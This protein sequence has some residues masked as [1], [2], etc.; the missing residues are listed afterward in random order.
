M[1]AIGLPTTDK[2]QTTNG[3]GTSEFDIAWRNFQNGTMPAPRSSGTGVSLI[4][5]ALDVWN[6]AQARYEDVTRAGRLQGYQNGTINPYASLHSAQLYERD[7]SALYNN[8]YA[9]RPTG[10]QTGVG[11][12]FAY[13]RAAKPLSDALSQLRGMLSGV[14]TSE[15]YNNKVVYP[16]K[17]QGMSSKEDVDAAL[18][19]LSGRADADAIVQ[20]YAGNGKGNS[21]TG[22]AENVSGVMHDLG[23]NALQNSKRYADNE[24]EIAWL[25]EHQYDYWSDADYA[26]AIK[27]LEGQLE[28]AKRHQTS[29]GNWEQTSTGVRRRNNGSGYMYD[30][31]SAADERDEAAQQRVQDLEAQLADLKSR[32][33][34]HLYMT[35]LSK[36]SQDDLELLMSYGEQSANIQ[37][38]TLAASAAQAGSMNPLAG[39]SIVRSTAAVGYGEASKVK[40]RLLDLGYSDAEAEALMDYIVKQYNAQGRQE[41][42]QFFDD[43][44]GKGFLGQAA[45][46]L[47]GVPFRLAGGVTGFTDAGIQYL[48]RGEDPF[49]GRKSTIDWNTA[50]QQ[51]FHAGQDAS[52]AVLNQ[53]KSPGWQ[54]A[55]NLMNSMLDSAAVA[56]IPGGE[57]LLGFS[58][59]MQSAEAAKARGA[60]DGQALLTGFFSGAAETACEH[61]PLENIRNIFKSTESAREGLKGIVYT[62]AKQSLYEGA[63]EAATDI[64]N[65]VTDDMIMGGMSEYNTRVRE[66]MSQGMSREEAE[67]KAAAE[68]VGTIFED[69]AAGFLSG[70]LMAGGAMGIHQTGTNIRNTG[71]GARINANDYG[72]ELREY[73]A[74]MPEGSESQRLLGKLD[75]ASGRRA[76]RLTGALYNAVQTEG[77]R[78]AIQT[79]LQELGATG[80]ASETAEAIRLQAAGAELTQQQRALTR[81]RAAQRVL[82]EFQSA[83]EGY[84]GM[85]NEWAYDAMRGAQE[86]D[87][88][89]LRR[90]S[91]SENVTRSRSY[92]S[93]DEFAESYGK[94]AE[95]VR[96][97]YALTPEADAADFATSFDAAYE[98]GQQGAK[99]EAVKNHNAVRALEPE[100]V[101]IAWQ[102]G[103][104]SAESGETPSV[105]SADS[106]LREGAGNNTNGGHTNGTE[107]HLRRGGERAD[108]ART[109]GEV[110]RMAEASKR[111]QTGK[112]AADRPADSGAL[113]VTV[114]G[115]ISPL[116]LGVENGS[117][118]QTAYTVTGNDT[119]SMKKARALA[120]EHGMEVVFFAG[121]NLGVHT[122]ADKTGYVANARGLVQGNKVFVRVDHPQFTADQIMRHE[123]GHKAIENGEIDLNE[124]RERIRNEFGPEQFDAIVQLYLDAYEGTELTADEIWEEIVCDS[125][126]DMNVFSDTFEGLQR[127]TGKLLR[128]TKKT[129]NELRGEKR[130]QESRAPPEGQKTSLEPGFENAFDEW[131]KNT[132]EEKRL[133]DGGRF[134][135]GV[136]SDKLQ[137]AGVDEYKIYFGKS[138]IAKIM[139]NPEMTAAVIKLVPQV[140][141]DPVIVMDSLTVPGSITMFGF[142]QTE[143]GKPVMVSML[144]HPES[145]TGEVLDYGVITSAYGRKLNNAQS[146]INRS[147]IRYIDP[148]TKRTE[149]WS[150][151]LGLH[152]PSASTINGSNNSISDSAE[153]SKTK[154]S[155][156]LDTRY[157]A[158]VESGDMETAQ[159]LVDEAAEK[160][161]YTVRAYHGTPNGTFNVFREWQY[162][163]ENK[164][165]ADRYQNQGASSNGYKPTATRPRTYDVYL[166]LENTFDTRKPRD[167]KIFNEEFYRQWGNGA[168]LSERGL[169][170]WTDGDD[171]AEF[172]D[173]NGYDY[174]S[175]YLDEGGTGGYGEEVQDRGISIA[176]KDPSQIKSA[177]PVTYDDNGDVVPLSKR[178]NSS[179]PDIRLS[180]DLE[181][182][183][184]LRREN[185]E[186]RERAKKWRRETLRSKGRETVRAEDVKE[187]AKSLIADMKSTIRPS[188]ITGDLT[189]L[190][191]YMMRGEGRNERTPAWTEIKERAGEIAEKL[192]DNAETMREG[193]DPELYNDMKRYVRETKMTIADEDKGDIPNGYDYFRRQNVGILRL[194]KDGLSVD[195]AYEQLQDAYGKGFFPDEFTHPADQLMRIADVIKGL[196]PV[197]ENPHSYNRAE[198]VEWAS[199]AIIDT[200][201][202]EDV[203][204]APPTFADRQA[205]KYDAYVRRSHAAIRRVREQRDRQIAKVKQEHREQKVRARERKTRSEMWRG[206]LALKRDF[207][208]MVDK[209]EKS[210]SRHAP[211]GLAIALRN[212]AD[213]FDREG[214]ASNGKVKLPEFKEAVVR[215]RDEYE[216]MKGESTLGF[217]YDPV[218]MERLAAVNLELRDVTDPEALTTGQ[219]R[220]IYDALRMCKH[221]ITTANK[222]IAMEY[223]KGITEAGRQ[224]S[225]E[226][227]N[228]TPLLKKGLGGQ[229]LNYQ[230]RPDSFFARISGFAKNSVGEQV[231][232]MFVDGT[233]KMLRIQQDFYYSLE[234]YST[235][236]R[237]DALTK[238]GNK[239]LV[240][241]GLKDMDGNTVKLTRDQMLAVYMHLRSED[242]LRAA[243][244]GGIDVPNARAYYTGDVAKSFDEHTRTA[245]IDASVVELVEE[246]RRLQ[247]LA[248]EDEARGENHPEIAARLEE[249]EAELQAREG[250]MI[251]T[252][253]DVR[254][255]I[256][257][258]LTDFEKELVQ[259]ADAWM[260][261]SAD[262]INA[263]T[264][265]MYGIE[266]AN[267]EHYWPIHRNTSFVNTDLRTATDEI[268]LENWGSLKERVRSH[269][270]VKLTGFIFE[271]DNHT[272]KMSQFCGFAAVQRDFNKLYN[273]QHPGMH[274]S[275]EEQVHKK[276]GS[277]EKRLGVSGQE[278]IDNYIKSISGGEHVKPSPIAWFRMNLPRATLSAN[279]RVALSQVASVPTA[280]AEVGW[281]AMAKGFARYSL[282]GLSAK[283]QEKLA[284]I[285]PW[286]WQRSRGEGG[287]REFAE[288]KESSFAF[289]RAYNKVAGTKVGKAI[290][291]WCQRFDMYAT[292]TQWAMAE[293]WVKKNRKDLE[294]GSAAWDEAVSHKYRDIIRKTQPNYTVTERSDLLRD[295]RETMKWATM[296]KTQSSQNLNILYDA[297]ARLRQYTRDF[298]NGKNGVTKA[299]LKDARQQFAR[300]YTGVILGGTVTFVLFRALA[301]ALLHSMNAYRDDDEELTLE[302]FLNGLWQET[303]GSLAGMF[304]L[305][306]ELEEIIMAAL[307]G[308]KYWGLS[309]SAVSALSDVTEDGL[310]LLNKIRSGSATQ[311]DY[312]KFINS[313]MAPLGIP[314]ENVEKIVNGIR[315]HVE[316]IQN[317]EFLSFEAG[318]NRTA[319]QQAHRFA[320]AMEDGDTAKMERIY[321]EMVT[322]STAEDPEGNTQGALRNQIKAAFIGEDGKSALS[323]SEAL[324]LLEQ[325]GGK[326][327]DDAQ[328]LLNK[329]KFEK[330][331]GFKYDDLKEAYL[332]GSISGKEYI[333]ARVEYAGKSEEEAE[334]EEL[335]LRCQKDYGVEYGE[336]SVVEAAVNGEI[337]TQEA[338]EIWT[339]YGGLSEKEAQSR[340][341]HLEFV[342]EHPETAYE[343]VSSAAV[344]GY[345]EYGKGARIPAEDFMEYWTHMDSYHADVDANGNTVN[346]SKKQKVVDYINGLR[347][348]DEQKTALYLA[349]GY[350]AKNIPTWT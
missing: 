160:A 330:E 347:I 343:D 175:I 177:D 332:D 317:G 282:K 70:G 296:Y 315:Y 189:A 184:D 278:Y 270:P 84:T 20:K 82:T 257:K 239:A 164:E 210:N 167:R 350:S 61:L 46:T 185:R 13:G 300:A 293:E 198:A 329:W 213:C 98:A 182:L 58:A 180:Q 147:N 120:A 173:E 64:L 274:T 79:R 134:L 152:L 9:S 233:E 107:V 345:N 326:S 4:D 7:L 321:R 109:L 1:S 30:Q 285:D 54:F 284:R 289:D 81:T 264:M 137:N 87:G 231:Q 230:L 286:F 256:E 290:L 80:N 52:G 181:S 280:A 247:K 166:K 51:L 144:L 135:I 186:L 254:A 291:N 10:T 221:N 110:R 219:L 124:V 26:N 78:Q 295:S 337:T 126:G 191:E 85:T 45:S 163:T 119:K 11:T 47:L 197:Y 324:K 306:S 260:R 212:V 43:L 305:G 333:S 75:N 101:A 117:T 56:P 145:K 309:D 214:R 57:V 150:K 159:R 123:M 258:Q 32:Q 161:G 151:A 136:T 328:E 341:D 22:L 165:Y 67:R 348:S 50:A 25:T 59:A 243:A 253:L 267:V 323:E 156:D 228:A 27:E 106:S 338:Y 240:D 115:K 162:F 226:I 252:L 292:Y 262:Y 195:S 174:D 342:I 310:D 48:M 206:I 31:P 194:G 302:S 255:E 176:V 283:Q 131:I 336:S 349:Y 118:A 172:F 297:T 211:M 331:Y 234:K 21:I 14:N 304:L 311:D 320:Q 207:Q 114:G 103:K 38:N 251:G 277:G 18:A 104:D 238:R 344:D 29:S 171:F 203:R 133:R 222:F 102:M 66:L 138:K 24:S 53:I 96:R 149:A 225:R 248:R 319:K 237:F 140:V 322:S 224:W 34:N 314:G 205:A 42:A 266:K 143:N 269:A 60:S 155:R 216:S 169:P 55:Y 209:P 339:K 268:N 223:A 86:M 36:L 188:E 112:K 5:N 88:R 316:D 201:L 8:L 335:K 200:L 299:D 97:V 17:Y 65:Y 76:N 325:F 125:L 340:V 15:D 261:K 139:Q 301:N 111:D 69:A 227:M 276:F 6:Q 250:K 3:R 204:Q 2:V 183:A 130:E 199:N 220:Q 313:L 16:L 39:G 236:K 44:A 132:T 105:R 62:L 190:A 272:K 263:E 19:A 40:Q 346:G 294:K 244:Y 100:Q 49:T 121:G 128:A 92:D 235:D 178:F 89:A 307:T 308:G 116:R 246:Q 122:R 129:A 33:E 12:K 298:K 72:A 312:R 196:K 334:K 279:F 23:K 37:N 95:A 232:Q 288:M 154:T 168:P 242:N 141:E 127:K 245:N 170:D 71:T 218:V 77:F 271:M 41:I 217:Y 113:K 275:L 318:L 90:G 148:D 68:F 35:E 146:L 229:L 287:M 273:V 281:G 28:D 215:L 249:I 74:A 158:A 63:E 157:T 93:I 327:G 259:A 94:Q 208:R 91:D 187:A 108:G 193:G 83:I 153:K 202:S 73:A 142:A 265:A 192:V 241:A 303:L 179:N 99:L